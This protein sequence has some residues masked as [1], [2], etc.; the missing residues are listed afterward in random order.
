MQK[1]IRMKARTG[2]IVENRLLLMEEM[3]VT[4]TRQMM[5]V[6]PVINNLPNIP[7]IRVEVSTATD[8]PNEAIASPVPSAAELQKDLP[9]IAIMM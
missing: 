3:F 4:I 5:V 6:V 8:W 1:L 2:P 7:K 9:D